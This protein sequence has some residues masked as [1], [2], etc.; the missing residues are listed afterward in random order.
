[1]NMA[2][3]CLVTWSCQSYSINVNIPKMHTVGAVVA[4]N[5]LQVVQKR[6]FIY[7]ATGFCILTIIYWN[8]Y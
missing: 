3:N 1:M 2:M 4:Y 7:I 8:N 6:V 5:F